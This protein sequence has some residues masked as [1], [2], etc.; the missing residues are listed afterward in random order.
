MSYNILTMWRSAQSVIGDKNKTTQYDGPMVAATAS[1]GRCFVWLNPAL[2][3][4]APPGLPLF[5]PSAK[6]PRTAAGAGAQSRVHSQSATPV[7]WSGAGSLPAATAAHQ[8]SGGRCLRAMV[9]TKQLSAE[10]RERISWERIPRHVALSMAFEREPVEASWLQ[11]LHRQAGP[12]DT[13]KPPSASHA[14]TL[15]RSRFLL[16]AWILVLCSLA[17]RLDNALQNQS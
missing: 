9:G 8:P 5:A 4:F 13:S 14:L 17:Q 2:R 10:E 6:P 1:P 7:N 11:K 12:P 16:P 15:S 3:P